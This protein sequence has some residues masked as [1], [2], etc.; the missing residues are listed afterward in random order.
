MPQRFPGRSLSAKPAGGPRIGTRGGSLPYL[1]R[2]RRLAK[3]VILGIAASSGGCLGTDD[4]GEAETTG[5]S[6]Q[7]TLY[8]HGPPW[9]RRLTVVDL[10][11]GEVR[12]APVPPA[13]AGDLPFRLVLTGGKLVYWG[14]AG[15]LALD[16][17]LRGA[18]QPLG[19]GAYFVPAASQG[20]IWLAM[21]D[22]TT[23]QSMRSLRAVREVA[24]DGRVTVPT[25]S[26]PRRRWS[27]LLGAVKDGL[28]LQQRR[29]ISVWDPRREKVIRRLRADNLIDTHG[30]LLAWA[31]VRAQRVHITDVGTGADTTVHSSGSFTYD[32][33]NGAFS[34]NGSRLALP[35][36]IGNNRWGLVVIATSTGVARLI[37]H[38]KQA[39]VP[40]VAWSASGRWLFFVGH[41]QG[42]IQAYQPGSRR[43][44]T[45]SVRI[46]TR[47]SPYGPGRAPAFLDLAAR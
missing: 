31:D 27:G 40:D 41:Q 20:H 8:L 3:L 44:I 30:N 35:V 33:V 12:R 43:A 11:A 37:E 46:P 36:R 9:E 2:M 29:R 1:R 19:K 47:P 25:I 13:G 42:R 10:N 34:P 45:V 18:P 6:P 32:D 16:A 38:A 24:V 39:D 23:P 5:E 14:A 21:L 15:A 17:E 22:P 4:A 28:V 26:L 7:G